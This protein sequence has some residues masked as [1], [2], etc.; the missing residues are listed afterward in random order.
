[1]VHNI[2]QLL[3]RDAYS[4][5]SCLSGRGI[6]PSTETLSAANLQSST[7]AQPAR[8]CAARVSLAM[9]MAHK[10]VSLGFLPCHSQSCRGMEAGQTS[11]VR[12][13][14]M[15]LLILMH[16]GTGRLSLRPPGWR[17][18]GRT[19]RPVAQAAWDEG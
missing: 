18:R 14:V 1:M 19:G 16:S 12:Q 10:T 6:S 9:L 5:T 2:Q 7:W 15:R 11:G 17:W 8:R 4:L 13:A 3:H